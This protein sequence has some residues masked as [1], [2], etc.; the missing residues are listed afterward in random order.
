[1]LTLGSKEKGPRTHMCSYTHTFDEPETIYSFPFRATLQMHGL[2]TLTRQLCAAQPI[3][4]S[5]ND[6]NSLLTAC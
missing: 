2:L 6:L 5:Y 4:L 1:M 3:M